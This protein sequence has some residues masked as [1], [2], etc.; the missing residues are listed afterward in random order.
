MEGADTVAVVMAEEDT[1]EDLVEVD[2]MAEALEDILLDSLVDAALEEAVVSVVIWVVD[3]TEEAVI[4]ED[5]AITRTEHMATP[6]SVLVR[7][8]TTLPGI[9]LRNVIPMAG[10]TEFGCHIIE[11]RGFFL[12]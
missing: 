6:T 9:G 11:G 3:G 10:A 8:H 1:P 5:G 4:G 2:F 7:I 12:N